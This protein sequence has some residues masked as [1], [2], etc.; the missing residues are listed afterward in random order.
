MKTTRSISCHPLQTSFHLHLNNRHQTNNSFTEQ[1]ETHQCNF[2]CLRQKTTR[3]TQA[4][5][6]QY[7]LLKLYSSHHVRR[8]ISFGG[9]LGLFYSFCFV[10]GSLLF[11]RLICNKKTSSSALGPS[12]TELNVRAPHSQLWVNSSKLAADGAPW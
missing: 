6:L 4:E 11:S 9:F 5:Q 7:W 3:D 10:F 1:L 12:R 2:S 8:Y